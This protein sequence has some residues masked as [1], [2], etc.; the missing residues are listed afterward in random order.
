MQWE[1]VSNRSFPHDVTFNHCAPS[2]LI[3]WHIWYTLE[4][5]K[6]QTHTSILYLYLSLS[7]LSFSLLIF[8]NKTETLSAE[9]RW[10]FL[11]LEINQDGSHCLKFR[12]MPKP[13]RSNYQI[14]ASCSS[15]CFC[16]IIVG[17]DSLLR[18]STPHT[19]SN[20]Y[21]DLYF[22]RELP[23]LRHCL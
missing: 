21:P 1:F 9:E 4:S 7:L 10:P 20:F 15:I 5:R 14:P 2:W 3:C 11:F 18:R 23:W 22:S 12:A 16:K 19:L 17:F 13:T 8:R 6:G